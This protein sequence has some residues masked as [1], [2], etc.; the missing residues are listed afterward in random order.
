M[1]DDTPRHGWRTFV[2][3]WA[4]QS[5]SL[6]GTALTFFAVNIWLTQVLYPRPEQKPQLAFALAANG[7]AFALP[8]IG[9]APIAGAWADRHDR[10]RTM[11]AMNVVAGVLTVAMLLLMA[12]HRIG[13]PGLLAFMVLYCLAGAFHAASFDTS[14]AMLVPGPQLPRANGMMQ[15]S[16]ALSGVVSPGLAATLIS[17]PALA[18]QGHFPDLGGGALGRMTD[19]TPLALAVDG[20]S[21]F[22]AAAVLLGLDIPSPKR[23]DRGAD[24]RPRASLIADVRAG[25]LYIGR[26][27]P[28]LWLLVTFAGANFIAAPMQVLQPLLVKFGLNHDWTARGFTFETALALLATAGSLG[29]VVGG[30]AISVWGGLRERRVR[31]V[32]VPLAVAGAIEI[33]YGLSPWIWLTAAMGFLAGSLIPAANAHSQAIWQA[34]VPRELQGRVFSVRRLVAQFTFPLGTAIAGALGG[35]IPPGLA[36]AVLGAAFMLFAATQLVNPALRRVEDKA[37]LDAEAARAGEVPREAVAVAG[38]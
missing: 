13:L 8:T 11:L 15:T 1:T 30:V 10:R 31:G 38:E 37:W 27:R 35:A 4:S 20:L 25:A 32:I 24:G 9:A 29:A 17:L 7:L 22:A 23:A 6:I 16:W 26:R 21:F 2:I 12:A 19:G 5:V 18:R 34:Q 3:A 33:A 28:L 14:Y 36:I